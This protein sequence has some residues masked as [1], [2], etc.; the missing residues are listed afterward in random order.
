MKPLSISLVCLAAVI[1]APVL[2]HAQDA[3]AEQ[4]LATVRAQG[5][6]HVDQRWY[7]VG[8]INT[9]FQL[10]VASNTGRFELQLSPESAG[11]AATPGGVEVIFTTQAGE[12]EVRDWDGRAELLFTG[13][14]LDQA[15]D[16]GGNVTVELRFKRQD[17]IARLA[18][19][20]P[21]RIRYS[22]S[23]A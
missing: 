7:G 11:A 2:A 10:C 23:P 6:T 15:C 1:G 12:R 4:P 21:S 13:R 8:D 22:V 9:K 17:L 3:P 5:T 16:I 20:H 19:D 18:G 14:A